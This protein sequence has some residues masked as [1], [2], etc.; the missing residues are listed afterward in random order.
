M[1]RLKGKVALVTGGNSGIGLATAKAFAREGAEVVITGRNRETLDQ[2]KAEVGNGIVA[3]QG[4]VSDLS[5]LDEVISTI[6]EKHGRIDVIF[7]NAG[8]AHPVPLAEVTE[9]HFDSHFNINVKGLL[10][11]IQKALPILSDGGSVIV[12]ASVVKD[13][14][15][16]GF[17]VYTA[18]KGAV[19]TFV[20]T[21]ANEFKDRGIRFNAVSPGPI[22]TPIYDRMGLPQEAQDEF[23]QSVVAQVPLGKFGDPGDIAE[24]VVYLASDEAKYT[25]GIDLAVDGGLSQV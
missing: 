17:S 18:T 9:E 24:A 23:G 4:D 2:A 5:H 13:K 7:A 6:K 22:A 11:T 19:R 21:W 10:F 3:L 15:F 25:N 16:P 1:G 14:G 20:R 12:N 8:V